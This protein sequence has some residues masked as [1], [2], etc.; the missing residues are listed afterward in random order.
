MAD[1]GTMYVRLKPY[2]QKRGYLVRRYMVAGHEF[3]TD[4]ETDRPIWN[5]VA[6][7]AAA[8]LKTL[9]QNPSD[10]ESKDL[11]DVVTSEEYEAIRE[12]EQAQVFAQLGLGEGPVRAP[13]AP[14]TIDRT[15]G[16]ASAIPDLGSVTAIGTGIKEP[17]GTSGEAPEA[18]PLDV[19]RA[20]LGS[21]SDE[22]GDEA[23]PAEPEAQPA[24]SARARGRVS[25][26]EDASP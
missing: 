25:R 26:S 5:K 15:G 19:A 14:P 7:R 1:N 2:D 9:K 17:G 12:R 4:N 20:A 16:R 8:F 21:S 10:S 13:A 24:S 22:G 3:M 18:T 6:A 23:P 11:F